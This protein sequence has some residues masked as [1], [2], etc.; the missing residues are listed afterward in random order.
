M[1]NKILKLAVLVFSLSSIGVGSVY[2]WKIKKSVD[3]L[4]SL[5]EVYKTAQSEEK[6]GHGSKEQD[7]HGASAKG[8]H[9]EA[10]KAEGE[11][12]GG[13]H[14]EG[15]GGGHGEAKAESG[16][17]G[18]G[19]AS[20]VSKGVPLFSVDELFVNVSSEK[21]AHMMGLKLELELFEAKNQELLKSRHSG[22]RDRIIEI[23]RDFE[24]EKLTSLSGKL[25]FKELVVGTLNEF[26]GQALVK[27]AH[28]SSFYLQ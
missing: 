16:H 9:G 5:P 19:P 11:G 3:S 8:E 2:I 27:D 10:A 26:F 24:Y 4:P 7:E 23:A 12:H 20:V 25:Y 13:E 1:K 14:G 6:E 18:R 22:V 28:I 21:G 17:E 15:H